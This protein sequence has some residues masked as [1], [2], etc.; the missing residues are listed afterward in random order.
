MSTH[1]GNEGQVK[2]GAVPV[3]EV[4]KFSLNIKVTPIE[5]NSM[6]DTWD[7]HIANSGRSNWSGSLDCHWD[8]TDTTGQGALVVGASVGLNLYFEGSTTGD[9]YYTGTATITSL[10][11][12]SAMEGTISSTF[13]FM[14]N[15]P[16]T[17]S[18][19]P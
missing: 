6:G 4:T 13:D 2:V 9:K 17:L 14:G 8:E 12:N 19:V 10:S 15:G 5:D 3:A 18:T 1:W 7:T 11:I 16:C